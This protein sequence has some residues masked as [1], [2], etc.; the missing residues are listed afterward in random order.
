MV[1]GVVKKQPSAA[2]ACATLDLLALARSQKLRCGP[3]DGTKQH[4]EFRGACF[5]LAGKSFLLTVNL[6]TQGRPGECFIE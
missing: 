5:A 4:C 2:V 6:K 1:L 3:N